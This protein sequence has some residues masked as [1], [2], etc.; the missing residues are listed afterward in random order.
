MLGLSHPSQHEAVR[1]PR[2]AACDVVTSNCRSSGTGLERGSWWPC[3]RCRRALTYLLVGWS[4]DQPKMRDTMLH[5]LVWW[6]NQ[7]CAH[8]TKLV[9]HQPAMAVSVSFVGHKL[10]L[11]QVIASMAIDPCIV[12]LALDLNIG[13]AQTAESIS[14][15]VNFE[16]CSKS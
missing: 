1:A 12:L 10:S 2:T 11:F 8:P 9:G 14:I 7:W 3:G 13:A 16:R 4:R 6:T 5:W 15:R